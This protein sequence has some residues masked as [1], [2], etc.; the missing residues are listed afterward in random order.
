M[1]RVSF[2]CLQTRTMVDMEMDPGS[3]VQEA[4]RKQE[5]LGTAYL[6]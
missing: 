4:F 1:I 3:G 5:E 2:N 6:T